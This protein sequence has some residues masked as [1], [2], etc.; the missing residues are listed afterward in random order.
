MERDSPTL[1]SISLSL[2][3][4]LLPHACGASS[5]QILQLGPLR[6]SLHFLQ[7]C[8][9]ATPQLAQQFLFPPPQRLF[10][11]REKGRESAEG[12]FSHPVHPSLQAAMEREV[13]FSPKWLSALWLLLLMILCFSNS[14]KAEITC[15]SC[16]IGNKWRARELLVRFDPTAQSAT[17]LKKEVFGADGDGAAESLQLRCTAGGTA[18][19]TSERG[20]RNRVTWN[21]VGKVSPVG[22]RAKRSSDGDEEVGSAS[23]LRR[24][25]RSE[26]RRTKQEEQKL[27]SSTFALTGD[28][29]HNQAMVHWSG[30][31]SSVSDLLSL[32]LSTIL[33]EGRSAQ[34]GKAPD[35][36]QVRARW[37]HRR[38]EIS[39][40]C[41]C[42]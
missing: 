2:D 20:R 9:W 39:C 29:S 22:N 17:G 32:P 15:R 27:N 38:G 16:Q 13:R 7:H 42:V 37:P 30:Q 5:D 11:P 41:D 6:L 28:S 1:S 36:R 34:E 8:I 19:C 24:A 25:T 40:E 26:E 35:E 21:S 18:G 33:Q 23:T 14:T 12:D 4:Q 10:I 3:A 31:N